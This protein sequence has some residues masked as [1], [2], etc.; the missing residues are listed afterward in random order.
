VP[1]TA[2][3]KL[4]LVASTDLGGLGAKDGS[5]VP[6]NWVLPGIAPFLLPWLIIL[7]LLVLKPNRCAAA[8]LIWLPL[9]CVV[10]L[11]Q[12]TPSFLPSGADF[13]LDAIAALAIGLAAVWLLAGYLRPQNRFVTFL[14]VLPALAGFSLLAMVAKQGLSLLTLETYAESLQIGIVLAVAVLASAAALSL[15]GLV[16]RGRYRPLG[17]YLWPLLLLAA[18]WLVMAAPFFV[19]ALLASG[20]SIPW[21][22]FFIPV[23]MVAVVNYATLLPFIILSSASPFYRGRLKAL[24]QVKP[25][26][27]PV[28]PPGPETGLKT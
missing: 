1:L 26:V 17:L 12:N 3:G 20:G 19:F 10:V 4:T 14:C 11:T 6:Y 21:S 23:L 24:L 9:G 5:P 28:M 7:V 27:P 2:G 13:L 22:E 15:C 16:C 8:W 25:V 18:L